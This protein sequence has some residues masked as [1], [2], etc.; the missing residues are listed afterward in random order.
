MYLDSGIT[1]VLT[2]AFLG[3]DTRRDLPKVSYSTALDYYVGTCFAFVLASIL[4]FAGVHIFTK[5]GSGEVISDD[6]TEED[7]E[8]DMSP[9]YRR[10]GLYHTQVTLCLR[11]LSYQVKNDFVVLALRSNLVRFSNH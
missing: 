8:E 2:M 5:Q 4:Q 11:C 1:T 3:L 9:E 6:E 10:G 7:D